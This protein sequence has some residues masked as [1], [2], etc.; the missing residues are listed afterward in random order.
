MQNI[1]LLFALSPIIVIVISSALLVYWYRK[2]HFHWTV[3]IFSL[4][5]YAGATGLKY[6]VQIPTINLVKDSGPFVLGAYYGVQTVAFEVGL[7][8]LVAWIAVRYQELGAR[9]GEGYGSGLGFWENAG[10][11]G[12][13]PLINY[14]AYFSILSSDSAVA[15]QLYDQL[16]A[17]APQLFASNQEALG[18]VALGVI[19]R[20][21]SLI[22]HFAWGYLC[23]M[24]AYHRKPLLFLIALPMGLIDFFVPFAASSIILFEVLFMALALA[25]VLIAWYITKDLRKKQETQQM[26]RTN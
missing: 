26:Q 1:N 21:S 12:I 4:A 24:A 13:L 16:M 11:L 18:L 22:I 19:E 6:A 9:D 3:L 23:F 10:L 2:R 25:S 20:T 17:N 7:A 8:F 14:V 15:Q 5:A